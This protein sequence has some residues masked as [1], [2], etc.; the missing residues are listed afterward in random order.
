[1]ITPLMLQRINELAH[2]KKT[3]GL[4]ERELVEQE[5]LRRVYIEHVKAQLRVSLESIKIV[6]EKAEATPQ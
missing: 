6:D 3:E 5:E 2:K 4:N 1:M